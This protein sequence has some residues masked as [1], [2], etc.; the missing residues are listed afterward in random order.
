MFL[1]KK[2]YKTS[3]KEKKNLYFYIDRNHA[4]H[5]I[6]VL[7]RFTEP[8]YVYFLLTQRTMWLIGTHARYMQMLP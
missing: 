6:H 2:P 1:M 3:K 8:L 5:I 4:A 7:K